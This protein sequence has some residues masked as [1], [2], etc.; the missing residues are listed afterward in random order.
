MALAISTTAAFTL[1]LVGAA[2]FSVSEKDQGWTYFQSLYFA[3][4]CLLTVRQSK[5]GIE[6]DSSVIQTGLRCLSTHKG[7][8][9]CAYY[10]R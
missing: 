4:T 9:E 7:S 3:Y 8:V 6:Y 5:C 1:W 2:I 10:E